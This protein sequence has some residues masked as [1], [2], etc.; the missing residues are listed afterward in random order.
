MFWAALLAAALGAC[1]PEREESIKAEPLEP[2]AYGEDEESN[3][4]LWLDTM[5]LS[6][7]ELYA[8]RN[9]VVEALDLEPGAR[10]ADL[11]AGT[12]L[13][14]LLLAPVV[15]PAGVVYAVDIEPLFLKLISQRA[16]DLDIGNVVAV[17]NREDDITLPEAAV[18]VVFIADTYHWLDDPQV[19]MASVRRA[20]APGGRLVLLEYD[21]TAGPLEPTFVHVRF[22]REGLTEEL[23]S[24]GF[25]LTATPDVE[26]LDRFY[27]AVFEPTDPE[28]ASDANLN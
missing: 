14:T 3:V 5:E 28:K 19:M 13:F 8:A 9:A 10:V 25:E 23:R 20:L 1:A 24:F 16:A 17:L 22:G 27:M 21:P 2:P 15:A 4:E 12:G 6:S 18:D 26:G 11:G 7:R